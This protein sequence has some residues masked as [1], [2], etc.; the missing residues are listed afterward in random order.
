MNEANLLSL[1][2]QSV[3][4]SKEQK[5]M[6]ETCRP[7]L[8]EARKSRQERKSILE[9]KQKNKQMATPLSTANESPAKVT[10]V[11]TDPDSAFETQNV[12]RGIELSDLHKQHRH[13]NPNSGQVHQD[14]GKYDT[15]SVGTEDVQTGR[16]ADDDRCS[17]HSGS[18]RSARSARS[19]Y[20]SSQASRASRSS[21]PM[22]HSPRS[23]SSLESAVSTQSE[24]SERSERSEHVLR[25]ARSDMSRR[26]GWSQHSGRPRWS[27]R[28]HGH[29][30]RGAYSSAT[31]NAQHDATLV[32]TTPFNAAGPSNA[33]GTAGGQGASMDPSTDPSTDPS[34]QPSNVQPSIAETKSWYQTNR[35]GRENRDRDMMATGATEATGNFLRGSPT[36]ARSSKRY[37]SPSGWNASHSVKSRGV[38]GDAD[39]LPETLEASPSARSEHSATSHHSLHAQKLDARHLYQ[40]ELKSR[41]KSLTHPEDSHASQGQN[42]DG[43]LRQQEMEYWKKKVSLEE[44]AAIKQAGMVLTLLSNVIESF[45]N[46]IGFKMIRI[47]GLST[48]MESAL[49]MGDF[50]LAI[51]SYISHPS[52][53]QLLQN[54]MASFV[55]SFGHVVLR[56]HLNNIKR[57]R[58]ASKKKAETVRVPPFDVYVNQTAARAQ[59]HPKSD[60]IPLST[61]PPTPPL[62]VRTVP[63]AASE[64]REETP[65]QVAHTK[66]AS[67]A[68]P[69]APM[70]TSGATVPLEQ[71]ATTTTSASTGATTGAV[72]TRARF[73]VPQNAQHGSKESAKEVTSQINS[74]IPMINGINKFMNVRQDGGADSSG[75]TLHKPD[76]GI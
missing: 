36:L 49:Q 72:Q 11:S 73:T 20:Y 59:A 32:S 34:L 46:A 54:P 12:S 44:Q 3:V 52:T 21:N 24:R 56:T 28:R 14:D 51:R 16:Y 65:S 17:E 29:L 50:D 35:C 1:A 9:Q 45:T 69:P 61:I 42:V 8:Q 58:A 75:T 60:S 55:T 62:H 63:P 47:Q 39:M 53:I 2:N 37:T 25:S 64:Q 70:V 71:S 68:L 38:G 19:V 57:E 74:L 5:Y 10:L 15:N 6:L 23:S 76:V 67:G 27:E 7:M 30:D 48:Q 13:H 4:M 18:A 26:S 22:S 31:N 40:Q 66:S 41:I 43:D 33:R